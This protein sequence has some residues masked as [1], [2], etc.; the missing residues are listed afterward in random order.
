VLDGIQAEMMAS[1]VDVGEF[2]E[3]PA[4]DLPDDAGAA[5]FVGTAEAA[6]ARPSA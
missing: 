6:E 5:A 2:E 3:A 4:E 1:G